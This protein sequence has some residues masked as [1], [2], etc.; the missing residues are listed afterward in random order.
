[1]LEYLVAKKGFT[2]FGIEASFPDALAVNEYV[3]HGSGDPAVALAGLQFWTWNTD[4]VLDMIK[5][6][7]A[8][9]ADPAHTS[10]VQFLGF[11]MQ[12]PDASVRKL[13]EYF[14][15]NG[16]DAAEA[17]KARDVKMLTTLLDAHK[18]DTREWELV[19]EEVRLLEQGA[20]VLGEKANTDS[21][22][23]DRYMA[24]N[25]KWILDH[26]PA[27][28]KMVLWAHNGHVQNRAA[29]E[30]PPWTPM[31][32]VLRRTYGGALVIFGFSFDHG[33]FQAMKYGAG[34]LQK[35]TVPPAPEGSLDALLAANA[36]PIA[37]LDL[38]TAGGAARQWLNEEQRTRWVGAVFDPSHEDVYLVRVNPLDAFDALLFVAQT[39]AAHG[40]VTHASFVQPPPDPKP[41]NL[42]FDE[43]KPGEPPPGWK[44]NSL[45]AGYRALVTTAG[46][47]SGPCVKV[48]RDAEQTRDGFGVLM[49]RVD[50]TPFRGKKI[51]F[52][53]R[54]RSD[55]P[56]G[57]SARLWLR[58]DR[59]KGVMGMLD[60]MADRLPGALPQWTELEAHGE[61][62]PDAEAIA[63]GLL[64]TGDGT[65][66]MDEAVLEVVE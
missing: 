40:R 10:K 62:A 36:P 6:M 8:W 14:T 24:E 29:A 49:Q 47:A 5:W 50:A 1:M 3:L 18:A 57:A 38:R 30:L 48:S 23:R 31:G 61:V 35:M 34:S 44:N 60:N 22:A 58:V 39:T 37:A 17:L 41:L 26:E 43:G 2:V 12:N 28:T 55:I 19:R 54:I 52:R 32:T 66:W 25:V 45:A 59:P 51:R 33:E 27:G 56:A 20:E 7:R 63:F 46:C 16:I 13:R 65:A 4:E 11:D 15:A 21:G 42:A 53:A 64:F 9:N